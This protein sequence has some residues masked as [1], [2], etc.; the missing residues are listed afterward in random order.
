MKARLLTL[1][2]CLSPLP[3]LAAEGPFRSADARQVQ[4]IMPASTTNTAQLQRGS[5]VMATIYTRALDD[6]NPKW[7]PANPHWNDVL[8][9]VHAD[10]Y[11][12]VSKVVQSDGNQFNQDFASAVAKNLS[13]K[14]LDVV[15]AYYHS[16]EGQ[17]YRAMVNEVDA[18]VGDSMTTLQR[19]AMSGAAPDKPT[20]LNLTAETYAAR[21]RLMELSEGFRIVQSKNGEQHDNDAQVLKVFLD[22]TM[23]YHGEALDQLSAKYGADLEH[24]ETFSHSAA[25]NNMFAAVASGTTA[26][27]PAIAA[28]QKKL[29]DTAQLHSG[30]WFKFYHEQTGTAPAAATPPLKPKAKIKAKPAP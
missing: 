3:A 2:L 20:A 15:I 13:Q 16:E 12:E 9:F 26:M 17:R 30:D 5:E 6:R 4:E 1:L 8:N 29:D 7:T 23:R 14:D 24:F 19:V 21:K 11:K 18:L 25:A 27:L 28:M 22:T 10:I